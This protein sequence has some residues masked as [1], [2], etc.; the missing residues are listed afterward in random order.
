LGAE[1]EEAEDEEISRL[2]NWSKRERR[3]SFLEGLSGVLEAMMEF[4]EV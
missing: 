4:S 1:D 3:L 2:G